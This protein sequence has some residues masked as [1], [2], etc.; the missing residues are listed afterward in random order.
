MLMEKNAGISQESHQQ[1]KWLTHQFQ[2]KLWKEQIVHIETAQRH[3]LEQFNQ[4]IVEEDNHVKQIDT[5]LLSMVT[6]SMTSEEA[7]LDYCTVLMF[8]RINSSD[9]ADFIWA[10]DLNI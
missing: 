6:D 3:K 5:N 4:K 9:I 10:H 7:V 8:N 2:I 1:S